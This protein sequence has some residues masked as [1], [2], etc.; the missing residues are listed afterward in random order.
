MP[1]SG[2]SG[3]GRGALHPGGSGLGTRARAA[4]HRRGRGGPPPIHARNGQRRG[5]VRQEVHGP[6][7]LQPVEELDRERFDPRPQPL[8]LA[9]DE[10][11]VD[12]RAQ[13]RVHGRFQL[14][15]RVHLDHVEIAEVASVVADDAVGDSRRALAPEAPVPEEPADIPRAGGTAVRSGTIATGDRNPRLP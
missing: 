5:E 4:P 6:A 10:G 12:Q 1:P 13:S 3:G 7:A 14:E 11:A 2:E 15:H 9:R 8:D